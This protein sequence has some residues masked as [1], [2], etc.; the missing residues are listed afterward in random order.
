MIAHRLIQCLALMAVAICL[1]FGGR[2][3][4][5]QVSEAHTAPV[6]LSIGSPSG[7]RTF[8][9]GCWSLVGIEI[10]NP[11][12][13]AA[14]VAATFHF[15]TAP[16][17]QFRRDL[18]LPAKSK[19]L[20][21]CPVLTP[22][23]TD[24][25][26]NEQN[27]SGSS[28]ELVCVVEMK[29]GD[30]WRTLTDLGGVPER[31]TFLSKTPETMISAMFPDEHELEPTVYAT[32]YDLLVAARIAA[33]RTRRTGEFSRPVY[34]DALRDLDAVDQVLL[35]SDIAFAQPATV[36]ALRD[37]LLAGGRIW[38]MLDRVDEANVQWL[39]GNNYRCAVVDR[40]DLTDVL[41]ES[42]MF[43]DV[44]PQ[45]T[46][47]ERPVPMVRVQTNE[48][49]VAYTVNGWPAAFFQ[50]YGR[51][52]VLF[53]TLGPE[54]WVRPYENNEPRPG[55]PDRQAS[56]TALPALEDL[57][58]IMFSPTSGQ[59]LENEDL[60]PYLAEQIGYR[61]VSRWPV[62]AVL[63]LFVV[64][65]A[66][67]GAALRRRHSRHA[68]WFAPALALIAAVP[69]G[70]MG[71]IKQH[72][73]PRTAALA[74]VVVMNPD[75]PYIHVTGSMALY[76]HEPG[77]T[78]V[79]S[80]AGG[81]I[82]PDRNGLE[83]TIR[84]IVWQDS[85]KWRWDALRL[86]AGV[87]EAK[88]D[89]SVTLPDP[90]RVETTFGPTG[91]QGKLS[92]APRQDLTDALILVPNAHGLAVKLAADGTFVGAVEESLA[93][94]T[95]SRDAILTDEQRRR[96]ELLATMYARRQ[97]T[98]FPSEPTLLAW[99]QPLDTGFQLADDLQRTGSALFY[100]PL[101]L[102]RPEPGT[103]VAIPAAFLPFRPVSGP[104][105][106]G[107]ASSYQ[108][109][110]GEWVKMTLS[111]DTWLR[112]QLPPSVLPIDVQRLTLRLQMTAPSR[113][114]RVAA[115][116]DGESVVLLEKPNPSGVLDFEISDP[117][118]LKTDE[119]GGLLLGLLISEPE[120]KERRSA[121]WRV[122]DL[123]L[124]VYGQVP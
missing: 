39:L 53:T 123:E 79:A 76:Q 33:G 95:F 50:N 96:Q 24:R 42:E 84:R 41:F 62:L 25:E 106:K 77:E 36:A 6:P 116:R 72:E 13:Q 94:G 81:Y 58:G 55:D 91:V 34:P 121:E 112:I 16:Y 56:F 73:V 70:L 108:P 93:R 9:P 118:L 119:T 99:S 35:H 107:V 82:L 74:Q 1:S 92:G 101:R 114:L 54:A 63:A 38:I 43:G 90:V 67:G 23:L 87:R 28:Y 60:Q 2:E 86:P 100:A 32:S 19:R 71:L 78:P 75:S 117:S 48:V 105:A 57:S 64:G 103:A 124:A 65:L 83:G 10:A 80:A 7:A 113:T 11:T 37:W 40:V 30:T 110:T 52:R 8:K 22:D 115:A 26:I 122:Q 85:A 59:P 12:D 45:N 15:K 47:F 3:A 29:E 61:I 31:T 97:E 98:K 27:A 66:V 102:T 69:I 17:L 109:A 104:T 20:A 5:A 68:A 120:E 46:N 21:T 18:W 44:V 4:A 111:S 14:T 89:V 49:E 51:G 88:F